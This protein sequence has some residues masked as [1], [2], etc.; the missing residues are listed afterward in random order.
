MLDNS[1]TP[2]P[3]CPAERNRSARRRHREAPL[4]SS[5]KNSNVLSGMISP[6]LRP[7]PSVKMP[8]QK[9]SGL[10]ENRSPLVTLI[11]LFFCITRTIR[12]HFL[13]LYYR[14]FI[15]AICLYSIRVSILSHHTCVINPITHNMDI[16][17]AIIAQ[18]FIIC[19]IWF[20]SV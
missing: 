15:Q 5:K 19:A 8:R 1:I 6:E 2:P 4:A 20:N 18:F 17:Y 11:L 3:R 9:T 10:S 14:T 13:S 16:S 12:L 7:E